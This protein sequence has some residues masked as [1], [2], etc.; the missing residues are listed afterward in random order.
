VTETIRNG[1]RGQPLTY[2]STSEKPTVTE[3]IGSDFGISKVTSLFSLG[4]LD[5][6]LPSLY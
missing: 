2:I 6:V 3:K 1:H 4:F 5:N